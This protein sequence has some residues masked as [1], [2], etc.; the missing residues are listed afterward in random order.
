MDIAPIVLFVFNRPEHTRKTIESLLANRLSDRSDLFIFSDGAKSLDDVKAVK[1]VREYLK[2]VKGFQ[3]IKIVEHYK[4]IGLANSVINGVEEIV[5]RFGRVIVIEDD[6]LLARGFLTYMNQALDIYEG[7]PKVFSVGGYSPPISI[8]QHYPFDSYLSY[9]CCT[10]GWG[11]W[12]DR[13]SRVDWQVKGF[14]EFINDSHLVKQFNRGG[15]DMSE[16]LRLQILGKINS[17]GIRWDF[18]HFKNEAFCFRPTQSLASSSGNDGSGIHCGIT[19]KYDV[20][21]SEKYNFLYPSNHE[22]QVDADINDK[23]AS[24]YDGKIRS[25]NSDQ[26]N[27]SNSIRPKFLP[28]LKALLSRLKSRGLN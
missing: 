17:W 9:R 22:L 8:S 23:F 24:F 28:K 7:N 27:V 18:A 6:L 11:T 4:N 15:D 20:E 14:H 21:L 13:W 10:W 16:L 12:A 2:G 19:D 26:A 3:S 1:K 25:R 5:Q